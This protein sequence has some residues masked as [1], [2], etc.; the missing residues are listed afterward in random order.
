[1]AS[2]GLFLVFLFSL[3]S[4]SQ[5]GAQTPAQPS[6][7]PAKRPAAA[8]R[9]ASA[10]L[11]V[12]VTDPAGVQAGAVRVTLEG[13]AQR[14]A[15]TEGGRIAFE[16]LPTGTY[17]LRFE[18]AGFVTL[19]REVI[20][21]GGA[22]IDVRVTLTPAPE[23]PEAPAPPAEA[24]PA[25]ASAAAPSPP[26]PSGV[27]AAPVV[28]DLPAFIEKNFVG[29]ESQKLS[30]LG[31]TTGATATLLQLKN[32]LDDHTHAEYDEYLYVIAGQGYTELQGRAQPLGAGD[33]VMIPR[34]VAHALAATGRNPIVMLSIRPG[35]RCITSGGAR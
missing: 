6:G 23:P 26:S 24:P 5:E 31:C 33:F 3:T 12:R 29:R 27:D 34:G 17:R 11:A 18:R 4:L 21:R 2:T 7:Q 8:P 25:A 20:A 19:E 16:N 28:I 14:T 15:T 10:T 35:D 30:A 1:M 32:R 13:P 9:P 22:P